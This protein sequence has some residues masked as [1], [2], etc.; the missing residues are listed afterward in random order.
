M[1][2][3]A[4]QVG[5]RRV[6]SGLGGHEEGVG[7]VDDGVKNASLPLWKRVRTAQSDHAT[8]SDFGGVDDQNSN[9]NRNGMS[10]SALLWRVLCVLSTGSIP[11]CWGKRIFEVSYRHVM[12]VV[13][14]N[15]TARSEMGYNS[16]FDTSRDAASFEWI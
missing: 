7:G 16:S 12:T 10:E 9:E 6:E 3:S 13:P 5:P 15:T 2:W 11:P 14:L 4:T 8:F 1:T